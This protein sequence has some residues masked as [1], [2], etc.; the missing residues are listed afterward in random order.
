MLSLLIYSLFHRLRGVPR[1]EEKQVVDWAISKLDLMR[2]KSKPVRELSGG[3]KRKLSVAIA[4]VGDPDVVLL[5]E[6]TS[7]DNDVFRWKIA[8]FETV[9]LADILFCITQKSFV[10]CYFNI[11]QT[12]S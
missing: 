6:P 8:W 1:K 2:H 3:N 11:F 7:G 9:V 5:D 10:E 12:A 4:L